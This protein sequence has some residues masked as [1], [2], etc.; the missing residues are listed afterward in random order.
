MTEFKGKVAAIT[1]AANGIGKA[2]AE[3]AA[4]R[5]MKLALLDIE[6]ETAEKVAEECETLGSPK[7][8]AIK[9]D[10]SIY[11]EVRLSV[12]RIMHE[13]GQIDVFFNNAGVCGA[14]SILNI[15]HQDWEWITGV[16]FLGMVYYVNEVLPIMAKQQTP[17]HFLFTSSIAGLNPGY[18]TQC[19][20]MAAKHAAL[21]LAE[22]VRDFAD[23]EA[24]YMGVSVFCPEY[25]KTTIHESEKRRPPQFTQACD[26]FY[27]TDDYKDYVQLFNHRILDLGANPRF[28]GP[29]L[30][31][32][33][34]DNQMYIVPHLH[35][36]KNVIE[37]HRRIEADMAKEE[38][39]YK[40]YQELMKWDD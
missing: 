34:E 12:K 35:T 6:Y 32:A 36:H 5:G 3:E 39:V 40:E 8:V 1:G 16:D 4:K 30:F 38:T 11:E 22:D 33:I 7:A 29:R 15:P 24:P 19:A 37:R 23:R 17:C 10:T 13:F 18:M 27:A 21:V 14:G 25:I 2:F 9:V 20:Y 31:R 26:P 28:V